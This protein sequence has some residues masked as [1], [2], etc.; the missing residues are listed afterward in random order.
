LSCWVAV[1]TA[2][3]AEKTARRHIARLAAEVTTEKRNARDAV[4]EAKKKKKK[5]ELIKRACPEA[6]PI[7]A[8]SKE[9]KR[10]REQ[11]RDCALHNAQRQ[12]TRT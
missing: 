6:P 4:S 9:R 1:S 3:A 10:E 5:P 2:R 8:R 12:S 7:T 11:H